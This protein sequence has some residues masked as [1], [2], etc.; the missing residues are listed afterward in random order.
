MELVHVELQRLIVKDSLRVP[1]HCLHALE[2]EVQHGRIA[3]RIVK[4]FDAF[5]LIDFELEETIFGCLGD[6][7]H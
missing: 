2:T 7:I 5:I 3:R 6:K 1:V 4:N